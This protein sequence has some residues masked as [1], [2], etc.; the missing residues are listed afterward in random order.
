VGYARAGSSPAFG[1]TLYNIFNKF[2]E[3]VSLANSSFLFGV[4]GRSN[5]WSRFEHIFLLIACEFTG[6][7]RIVLEEPYIS[8]SYISL[9]LT[10]DYFPDI[11]DTQ[12]EL[13]IIF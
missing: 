3:L 9:S 10:N 2:G 4:A 12:K 8:L 1:T 7:Y 6:G 5:Q 11:V 13:S